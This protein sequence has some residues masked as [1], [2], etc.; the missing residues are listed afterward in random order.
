ML[1]KI[2]TGI[3]SLFVETEKVL[4]PEVIDITEDVN[5]AIKNQSVDDL[6]NA[7][8]PK[9]GGVPSALLTGA[10][11]LIPKV[12]A[13]ELGLQ[14]LQTGATPQDAANWAQSVIAAFSTRTDITSKS[15]VWTNLAASLA[16]LFDQ[17]KTQNKNWVYWVN[18]ADTAFNQI[19]T[20]V[21]AASS[22]IIT[23][24]ASLTSKS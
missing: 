15:K 6:V 17:G 24:V 7:L 3:K 8:S 9:L 2:W 14:A 11:V 5:N 10:Q 13:A 16:V 23:P 20:A 4:L 12:L 22:A 19:Q 18:L 21:T 1:G